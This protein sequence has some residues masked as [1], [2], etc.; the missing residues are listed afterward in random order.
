MAWNF[1]YAEWGPLI[2]S[3]MPKT[4]LFRVRDSNV[5]VVVGCTHLGNKAVQEMV[6]DP[7]AT[8]DQR[9][10]LCCKVCGAT[11]GSVV[12]VASGKPDCDFRALM[13]VVGFRI[14]EEILG[15]QR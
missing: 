10:C 5:G 6:D 1:H 8:K 7:N 15:D 14:A 2:V 3:V 13:R 11:P 9:G 4:K 12:H